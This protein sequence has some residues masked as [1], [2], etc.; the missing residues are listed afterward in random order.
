MSDASRKDPASTEARARAAAQGSGSFLSEFVY[1]LKRTKK[2]WAI[3]IVVVLLVLG[4]LFV[5]SSTGA[6]PLIYTLF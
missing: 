5:L 2:W 4:A 6:A 3:P 1:L